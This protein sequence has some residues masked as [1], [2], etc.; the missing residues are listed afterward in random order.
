[1]T[2][3]GPLEQGMRRMPSTAPLR[4]GDGPAHAGV[5]AAMFAIWVALSAL[6]AILAR[7]PMTSNSRTASATRYTAS[8]A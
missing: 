6:L 8:K 5:A 4:I 1:V 2:V 7:W 3:A